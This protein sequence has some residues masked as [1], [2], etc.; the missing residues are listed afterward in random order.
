MK[1]VGAVQCRAIVVGLVIAGTAVPAVAQEAGSLLREMQRQQELQRQE[2]LPAPDEIRPWQPPAAIPDRGERIIVKGVR[3]TGKVELLPQAEREQLAASVRGKRLGIKGLYALADQVTAVL[4]GRGR[5]L[6][7]ALLPPQD[8]TNGI[9]TIEIAEGALKTITLDRARGVRVREDLLRAIIEGRL[10]PDGVTR[11]DL[12]DA[13]LRM[14][15]L[16][17]VSVHAK[18]APGDA[19]NTSKLVVG[20]AQAPVVGG[21]LWGDN[22]GSANVGK[23]QGNG[24]IS[25]TDVSGYGDLTRLSGT[26]SQGQEYGS[27]TTSVPL[28]ASGF[29]ANANYS[30]LDYH[31]IDAIGRALGLTGFAHFAN[32]GVDYSLIR[33]RDFNLQ[34]GGAVTWKA[35]VDDSIVGKLQDKRSTSGTLSL[36]GDRRDALLG[37]GITNWS[38]SWT[39]GDL[40][41]S[42][43]P[44][45]L[46][47]DLA[48][49]RTQG[50]FNRI[51]AAVA[52]LQALPGDFALFGRLYGQWA[53]KNL[54]SSEDF[55]LGGP[56]GVRGYPVG[57]A[58]GDM[59]VLGTL[60]LRYYAPLPVRFGSLQ[61]ASFLDGGYVKIN[62][63]PN[64]IAPVTVCGCNEYGLAS[65]GLAA[66]WT[67]EWLNVSANWAHTLGDNPGRSIITGANVDGVKAN[68]QFWLQAG[69]RF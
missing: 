4:Q 27:L 24:L 62:V 30:Y 69:I 48:G 41:L 67:R 11:Q 18:L 26:L 40:D 29:I 33:S 37:G 5:L 60:E 47:A 53:D 22:Y 12:E 15:D 6:A 58:R 61:L 43:L 57:E 52:R 25:L 16:P 50:Q 55:A 28:G 51:N 21:G 19:P 20:V 8:I 64:G 35:L 32:G 42:R 9:V 44:G 1:V 23:A 66:R 7:R 14:N 13:L 63:S 39:F 68:D 49:L 17:G 36:N 45:A 10:K 59:G 38:V 2:R 65:A 3:F 54:D 46:A 56:F 34:L 31:N